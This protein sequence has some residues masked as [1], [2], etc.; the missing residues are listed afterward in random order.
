V[1]GEPDPEARTVLDRVASEEA[2][3]LEEA[4]GVVAQVG[5][6]QQARLDQLTHARRALLVR[7]VAV[8]GRGCL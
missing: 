4:L 3:R 6:A 2:V 7:H 5:V 1:H 8:D